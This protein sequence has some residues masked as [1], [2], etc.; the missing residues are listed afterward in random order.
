MFLSEANNSLMAK[1]RKKTKLLN[2]LRKVKKK[3]KTSPILQMIDN[4][5]SVHISDTRIASFTTLSKYFKEKK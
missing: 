2:A 3:K 5:K 1:A 4:L